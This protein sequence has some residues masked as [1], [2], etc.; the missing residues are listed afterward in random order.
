MIRIKNE[1]LMNMDQDKNYII[2]NGHNEKIQLNYDEIVFA[3]ALGWYIKIVT[4]T[5]TYTISK[6]ILKVRIIQL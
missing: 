3:Q 5:N 4:K 1:L 2:I 6:T